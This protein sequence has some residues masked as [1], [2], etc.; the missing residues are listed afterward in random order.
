M[1]VKSDETSYVSIELVNAQT[2]TFYGN[3]EACHG[4]TKLEMR[5]YNPEVWRRIRTEVDNIIDALE[6]QEK[7]DEENENH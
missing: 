4:T 3:I 1:K 6:R 2:G 7:K 5:I